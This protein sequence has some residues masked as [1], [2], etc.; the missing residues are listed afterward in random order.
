MK[1]RKRVDA[2]FSV[3]FVLFW[4]RK[5]TL[6]WYLSLELL[7]V[8]DAVLGDLQLY[9]WSVGTRLTWIKGRAQSC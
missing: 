2:T 4:L 7:Q 3:L 9:V 5:T 6:K 1:A 8:I